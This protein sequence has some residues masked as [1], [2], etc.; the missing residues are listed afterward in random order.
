MLIKSLLNSYSNYDQVERRKKSRLE[1]QQELFQR[2]RSRKHSNLVR[3][4]SVDIDT[5]EV[6]SDFS[7]GDECF[8]IYNPK[9]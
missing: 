3:T 5:L 1:F 6:D 7:S 4:E 9:G 8:F 2:K